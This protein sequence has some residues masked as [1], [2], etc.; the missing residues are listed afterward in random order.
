MPQLPAPI[1]LLRRFCPAD[2]L[3][4]LEGDLLEKYETDQN[5]ISKRKAKIR[6]WWNVARLF[7]PVILMRNKVG[8]SQLQMGLLANYLRV[9]QRNFFKD[10]FY[11]I[12]NALGLSLAFTFAFLSLLYIQYEASFDQF[13]TNKD[14]IYRV[15]HKFSN[16]T[17]GEVKGHSAVTAIPLARDLAAEVP[18]VKHFSRLASS[19]A[20][21]TTDQ[22]VYLEQVH[23]VDEGFLQ[24]FDFPVIDG[25]P[26]VVPEQHT[27]LISTQKAQ[28]LF[29]NIPGIG[30]QFEINLGDSLVNVQVGGIVNNK[31]DRSSIPF[32]FLL[33]IELFKLVAAESFESY[34]YG[35]VENYIQLSEGTDLHRVQ[36]A[37]QTGLRKYINDDE[38]IVE[39]QLQPFTGLHFEHSIIGN[40]RYTNPLKLWILLALLI[41]VIFIA[42]ANYLSMSFSQAMRRSSE[43]AM[44]HTLGALNSQIWKQLTAESIL[45]ISFAMVMGLIATYFFLPLYNKLVGEPIAYHIGERILAL[46]LLTVLVVGLLTGSIQATVLNLNRRKGLAKQMQLPKNGIRFTQILVVFQLALCVILLIGSTYVRRQINFIQQKDL[47][48]QK[49]LLVDITLNSDGNT[50]DAESVL[51][52]FR[53]LAKRHPQIVDVAGSMN[54]FSEPWTELVFDQ[55]D[56]SKEKIFFNQIEPS[57]LNTLGIKLV[58][59]Q[60]FYQDQSRSSASILVNE[61]LVQHFGWDDAIGKQ[62]P[63]QNFEVAH[64]IIGVVKDYHFSPLHEEIKPL[65]LALSAQPIR[66]GITGLSTYVWPPNF[67]R[68]YARLTPGELTTSI[69]LLRSIWKEIMPAKP[70]VYQFV[71]DELNARYMEELR[72]SKIA[73]TATIMA[74]FI[75]WLG[76]M[77]T[78]RLSIQSRTK[79]IGMR[80]ILGSSTLGILTRLAKQNM[81]QVAMGCIIAFPIAWI[82][83]SNW[84]E[85]FVYRVTMSPLIFIGLALIVLICTSTSVGLQSI[86]LA[87]RSPISSLRE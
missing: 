25:P 7:H 82:L 74:I 76:L 2:L 12:T 86:R 39:W 21:I 57:Y 4:S 36:T 14:T 17:S 42:V 53:S 72:W 22:D 26:G 6:L 31:K 59:G 55:V 46:S 35:L 33:D 24:M 85:S 49:D 45:S 28:Q 68:I 44:R 62:I 23:F 64:Q 3:E 71:E 38:N 67:Y 34:K 11:S 43:I 81:V 30:A 15:A 13:H 79:E 40:A 87:S 41:L 58:S 19:S 9:G 65:I 54:N 20:T 10:P 27:V 69:N 73:N 50:N 52:T 60:P 47:G 84:L 77:A 83:I 56:G 51:Q 1:R 61:T 70:F 63:G 48:Y 80:K 18:A 5:R 66:S 32:D 75:A 37:I 8:E 78:M 16:R 29:G